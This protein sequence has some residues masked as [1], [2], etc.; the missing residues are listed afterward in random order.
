MQ[1][2]GGSTRHK[3]RRRDDSEPFPHNI[4]SSLNVFGNRMRYFI[5]CCRNKSNTY[6][7]QPPCKILRSQTQTNLILCSGK[8]MRHLY[9][10]GEITEATSRVVEPELREIRERKF[11]EFADLL[12]NPHLE[13]VPKERFI[14]F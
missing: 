14:A 1:S 6:V 7:E 2:S 13:V 12:E 4:R 9:E 10:Y 5:R 8:Y 11:K 3:R